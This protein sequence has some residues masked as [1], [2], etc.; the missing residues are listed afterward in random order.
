MAITEIG[1]GI[2]FLSALHVPA[3]RQACLYN[4]HVLCLQIDWLDFLQT[5]FRDS[6]VN[7]TSEHHVYTGGNSY[8]KFI[9]Q[10]FKESESRLLGK[11]G[12]QGL[13][14]D[15]MVLVTAQRLLPTA[16]GL[17][18]ATCRLRVQLITV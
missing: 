1:L 6:G 10:L 3:S 18:S 17:L 2:R 11:T 8:I 14:I 12:R 15:C 4:T 5:V 13:V 7:V 9:L 16:R